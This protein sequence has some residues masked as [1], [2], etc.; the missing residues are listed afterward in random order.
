M[1]KSI[2]EFQTMT[3]IFLE[4]FNF[5]WNDVIGTT[6]AHSKQL[7]IGNRLRPQ[8]CL[9]G[10]LATIQSNKFLSHDYSK[11]ANLAV[12]IEM[13]HKASLLIDDWIDNDGKRHGI[14]TFHVKHNPQQAV[15]LA[16]NLIGNSMNRLENVF[17][18]NAVLPH[19]YYLCLNQLIKTVC[20]MAKGALKELQL[21]NT[22]VFDNDKIHDIIQ[23]EVS[24]ILGNSLL[25]GYYAGAG[26]SINPEIERMFKEIGDKCGYL[27]QAYNDLEA[28]VCP[29]KL[30]KHKGNLNLDYQ[31]NRKN[32]ALTALFE[33]ASI[34]DR[35]AL[36]SANEKLII[37][38]MGKYRVVDTIYA[39]LDNV[40]LDL[41]E[42]CN[43]YNVGE[44]MS[45][46]S[47]CFQEFLISVRKIAE[48]RLK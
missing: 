35:R 7:E 24:E 26:D 44:T 23:L 27:F 41:L 18:D 6:D 20:A 32:L 17:S 40:F 11:I 45:A 42:T 30:I 36:Q 13:V 39:E 3:E 2:P 43:H 15:L 4:K 9:W 38:M 12:S 46:W 14:P 47:N 10:Y 21:S 25:L 16:L 37:Q 48:S 33:M 1:R 5:Y 19:N 22:D 34:E 29:E 28:F 31:S 8:M